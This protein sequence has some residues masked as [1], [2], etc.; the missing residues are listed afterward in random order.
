[1]KQRLPIIKTSSGLD[2]PKEQRFAV[3]VDKDKAKE[4]EQDF[5][6]YKVNL[7][8]EIDGNITSKKDRNYKT[9]RIGRLYLIQQ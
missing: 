4:V 5:A 2:I 8:Y 7:E 3:L 1:M 9:R 6:D